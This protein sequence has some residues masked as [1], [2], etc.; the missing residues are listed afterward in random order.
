MSP[1]SLVL[2]LLAALA[3]AACGSGT[4][5]TTIVPKSDAP[6]ASPTDAP[7]ASPT[8]APVATATDAPAGDT[9]VEIFDNGF[10]ASNLTVAAGSTVTWTNIGDRPHS[11]RSTDSGFEGSDVLSGGGTYE[12]TFDAAGTFAY[13][14]G[15]HAS[16]TGTITVKP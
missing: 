3:A 1:R 8:D 7:V 15:I 6:V 16:M 14:C 5:T 13:V 12:H 4:P 2:V 11:V 10:R 9:A